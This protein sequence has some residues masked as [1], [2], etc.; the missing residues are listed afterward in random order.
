[1]RKII[2]TQR[3]ANPTKKPKLSFVLIDK[4]DSNMSVIYKYENVFFLD[5]EWK[6]YW[7]KG[8]AA[9][10]GHYGC[11]HNRHTDGTVS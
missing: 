10:H 3:L 11:N 6:V 2:F 9:C 1:M 8:N 4:Q 7:P 5:T